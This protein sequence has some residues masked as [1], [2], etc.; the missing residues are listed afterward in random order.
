MLAERP[1]ERLG[2]GAGVTGD[3]EVEVG[4]RAAERRV[5]DRPTG[6]PDAL[7]PAQRG[8]RRRGYRR[9]AEVVGE[10]QAAAPGA[11][12]GRAVVAALTLCPLRRGA[13]G[14]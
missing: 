8:D 7:S 5:A 11:M 12:A 13:R 6:D 2:D 10:A 14:R 3:G 4:D 1:A 9:G